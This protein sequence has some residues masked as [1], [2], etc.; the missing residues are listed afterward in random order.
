MPAN[1][2][3]EYLKAQERYAR[4]KT[5]EERFSITE[6]LIRLAPKHKGTEKLLKMLRRRLAKLRQELREREAKRAGKSTQVFAVKKEG[7]LQLVLLG[8]PNSGKST[9]LRK[10]T[11]ARPAVAEYPFTTLTP[12]PGMMVVGDVQI[13]LVEAPA[14]VEGAVSGKGLGARPLSLARVAD[15]VGLVISAARDPLREFEILLSELEVSGVRLNQQAPKVSV[16]QRAAGGIVVRGEQL[17]EGGEAAVREVLEEHGIRNAVVMIQ[18]PVTVERL[19]EIVGS[20]VEYRR[21]LVLVTKCDLPGAEEKLQRLRERLSGTFE[22]IPVTGEVEEVKRRIYETLGL[23]KVYTKPPDG[24][25]AERPLVVQQGATVLDIA[26]AV[27]RD[28]ERRL[29]FA[30]VWGSTKFPGQQVSRDY[31]VQDGDVVELHVA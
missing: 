15:V 31:R 7:A 17:V 30:R 13:Q 29:R 1:L 12:E 21:A 24:K 3:P 25:P 8:L 27:H 9:L 14:V 10:L 23:V 16:E 18:E 5:L 2:P 19:R 4:A 26:K 20:S 28:F 6:E 11:G 22:I